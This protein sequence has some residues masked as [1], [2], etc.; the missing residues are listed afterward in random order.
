[1]PANT[2]KKLMKMAEL[3][4]RTGV[5]KQAIHFYINKGLLPRPL[6]TKRNVAYYDD[7]FIERIKLIKELQLKRFLP[8]N[9]IKEI[10]DRTDGDLSVSEIDVIRTTG[11][12][13]QHL[14]DIGEEPE[15][16]SLAELSERTGLSIT[17]I[18]EMER[19]EMISSTADENGEK[20]FKGLDIR[21]A[22]AFSEVRGA[23]LTENVG[24][25]VEDFR[26]QSDLINMLAIEEVKVFARKF[27]NRYPEDAQE[28]LPQI[29]KNSVKALESFISYIRQKKLLEA[30]KAFSEGGV[31]ALDQVGKEESGKDSL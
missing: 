30:L 1:M 19:C 5:E 8:L 2:G 10:I 4:K 21:I 13:P 31:E 27:A 9:I 25:S 14:I 23:G 22:E 28:L 12:E 7:T 11:R 26:L 29:A 16:C 18:E 24:F 6:K 3:V 20:I 17:E 15:P